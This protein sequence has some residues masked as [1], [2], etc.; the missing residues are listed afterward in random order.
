[1]AI[2][3]TL[4]Y[5]FILVVRQVLEPKLVADNLGIHP[6]A[7][8]IAI[9]VGYKLFGIIGLIL[10]PFILVIGKASSRAHLFSRWF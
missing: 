5:A 8:L 1:M 2:G 4:L 7:T 10:G 3:L 6:L 9:Y